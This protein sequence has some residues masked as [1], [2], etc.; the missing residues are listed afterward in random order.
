MEANRMFFQTF[1]FGLKFKRET[2][3]MHVCA[4]AGKYIRCC[5]MAFTFFDTEYLLQQWQLYLFQVWI[6]TA[7]AAAATLLIS[8]F[9]FL[10]SNP[11]R[12]N[13]YKPT[14]QRYW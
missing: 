6:F 9:R 8:L 4:A 7:A 13:I 5:I 14:S 2:K 1:A 10:C 11:Q 12:V 3:V